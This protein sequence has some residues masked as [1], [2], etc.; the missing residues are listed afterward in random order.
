[1]IQDGL[2]FLVL[3]LSAAGSLTPS[4]AGADVNIRTRGAAPPPPPPIVVAAPPQLVVVPG[5]PVYYVPSAS[6]NLFVFNG[7]YYSFHN[8]AWFYA[9]TARGPWKL[10]AVERVPRPVL[11]V[12]VAYYK[13]PPGHARKLEGPAGP[14]A[15]NGHGKGPKGKKGHDD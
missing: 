11:A 3:A 1:M 9:A 5:T 10:I 13:I 4:P 12:P 8:G 14:P 6:F 2:L 7:R 15:A